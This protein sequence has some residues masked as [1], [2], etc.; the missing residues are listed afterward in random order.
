MTTPE[1]ANAGTTQAPT[2]SAVTP[3]VPTTTAVR[4]GQSSRLYDIQF[5]KND[6][7]NFTTW[8]YRIT[9]ILMQRGLWKIVSGAEPAPDATADP[10]A[11]AE[12]SSRD[13]DAINT[14]VSNCK[15]TIVPLVAQIRELP[16]FTFDLIP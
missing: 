4:T 6:G 10:D 9:R 2:A 5:L 3:Q 14:A 11:F 13:N 15:D 12:W 8:K 7:S 16:T 1:D